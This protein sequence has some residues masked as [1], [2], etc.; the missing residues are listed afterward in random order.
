MENQ[1]VY[2]PVIV[3]VG[4]NRIDSLLRLLD[5]LETAVYPCD[6]ITLYV[7]LDHSGMEES[8]IKAVEQTP[9]THGKRIIRKHTGQLGLRKHIL[10]CASLSEQYGSVIILEDD[11]VVAE[12][13][14]SYTVQALDYYGDQ[15]MIAGISLYS[16]AWNEHGDYH[17][18]PQQN[19]YDTYLGQFSCT[20]GQCWTNK[21]WNR[22]K[23]WYDEHENRLGENKNIPVDVENWGD[24]SWGKYFVY[25]M[26]E[27][28]L[29]YV[30]P[31]VA[32]STNCSELG[33]HNGIKNASYQVML[34]E[35]ADKQY[36][37]P[38]IDTAVKYDIFFERVFSSISISGIPCEDI[39]INLNG[40]KR[41][42]ERRNYLITPVP[43]S[44]FKPVDSF[45]LQ[46]RPIEK[47]L[48]MNCKGN[49]LF[50][51]QVSESNE[52]I[53]LTP[54]GDRSLQRATYE[55]YN[56]GWMKAFR[57][58]SNDFAVALKHFITRK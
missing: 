20:W 52:L 56:S 14:Y 9:W 54:K 47:N 17:F 23:A 21:Q 30:M 50:M 1:N 7:S 40:L 19:G 16:H 58:A 18:M 42:N 51:Y 35:S 28:G 33:E 45:E 49:D 8:V 4:Y 34:M 38:D 6:D 31:Y 13:F 46:F 29:Y 10:E 44:R 24:K 12:N 32:L 53:E 41:T 25:F 39:C 57:Y 11:L 36:R 15:N 22:F 48:T 5:S 43:E 37:F 3:A 55:I 2:K 27:N 26:V